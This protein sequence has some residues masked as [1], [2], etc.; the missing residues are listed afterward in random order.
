M[1]KAVQKQW[2]EDYIKPGLM[3]WSSPFQTSS[4]ALCVW[5]GVSVFSLRKPKNKKKERALFCFASKPS[6]LSFAEV[7]SCPKGKFLLVRACY[8]IQQISGFFS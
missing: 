1:K 6:T 5:Q 3:V 8:T 2:Q 4:T 7:F